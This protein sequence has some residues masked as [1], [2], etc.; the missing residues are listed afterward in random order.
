M[1]RQ[2]RNAVGAALALIASATVTRRRRSSAMPSPPIRTGRAS[3]PR[4][5]PVPDARGECGAGNAPVYRLYNN[6]RNDANHAYTP[7]AAKRAA[8]L[9]SGFVEEGSRSAWRPIPAIRVDRLHGGNRAEA[10]AGA[11]VQELGEEFLPEA[12]V[13]RLDA[14]ECPEVTKQR[15]T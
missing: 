13:D 5:T 2:I 4:S 11:L 10:L 14:P 12:S 9:A 8:L 7:H 6:G 3:A 15:S 1:N